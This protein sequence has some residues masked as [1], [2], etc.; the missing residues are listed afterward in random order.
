[1]NYI[2]IDKIENFIKIDNNDIL[3]YFIHNFKRNYF[4]FPEIEQQKAWE[5]SIRYLKGTLNDK[6]LY[7]H[8]LVFEYRLP[9]SNERIDLIIFGK[10]KNEKY[11]IILFE[12]K[13]W[14]YAEQ[15]SDYIINSDLGQTM[16]PLY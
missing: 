12:L 9:L 6:R 10:T 3:K 14:L 2:F 15:L 8:I 5:S 1:M 4:K 7:N 16:H 13:G 11:K